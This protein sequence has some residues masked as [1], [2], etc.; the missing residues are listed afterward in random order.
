MTSNCLSSS[1]SLVV[2]FA[3]LFVVSYAKYVT[4]LLGSPH[5][6]VAPSVCTKVRLF[7]TCRSTR[8]VVSSLVSPFGSSLF[9][10]ASFAPH[11]LDLQIRSYR[12]GEFQVLDSDSELRRSHYKIRLFFHIFF[13]RYFCTLIDLSPLIKSY[14][15]TC[16][17]QIVPST[18]KFGCFLIRGG[19]LRSMKHAGFPLNVVPCGVCLVS[20]FGTQVISAHCN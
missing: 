9:V 2:R 19:S 3:L 4:Y 11:S 20:F 7:V 17:N 15:P 1:F 18:F 6:F 8:L 5:S 10:F 14:F 16:P 12:N 13:K